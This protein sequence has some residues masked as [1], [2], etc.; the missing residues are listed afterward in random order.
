MRTVIGLFTVGLVVAQLSAAN[1]ATDVLRFPANNTFLNAASNDPVTGNST[2]VG[3]TRELGQSGGP[4]Y[5]LFYLVSNADTGLFL[6]GSGVIDAQ[7]FQATP[8]HGS[9]F[10]D[11]NTLTLETQIGAVPANGIID[12]E[13]NGTGAQ[14][15]SG[16]TFFQFENVR[17]IIAGTDVTNVANITGS[18]F[19]TPLVDPFGD[20]RMLRSGT[21]VITRQ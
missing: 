10:V 5:R 17:G 11:I 8:Q 6:L 15:Q 3:V 12:I 13:W 20:I 21:V 7:D 16:A 14:R 18:V 1:A 9:L 19:G 4:V 2:S